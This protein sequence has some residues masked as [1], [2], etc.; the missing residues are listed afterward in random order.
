[1]VGEDAYYELDHSRI[2]NR[3]HRL[4]EQDDALWS[5]AFDYGFFQGQYSI[6]QTVQLRHPPGDQNPL[7]PAVWEL[8]QAPTTISERRCARSMGSGCMGPSNQPP[9][10]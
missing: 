8:F 10:A 5:V 6:S 2:G 3:L 7:S 4:S 9:S 1:M